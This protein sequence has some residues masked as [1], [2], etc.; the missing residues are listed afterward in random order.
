MAEPKAKTLQQKLGFFDE[1]L[2]KPLHDD[3][4]KW[5]D[6]NAEEIIYG[7]YPQLLQFSD[8]KM[9]ELRKRCT[10]IL[11]SN[12]EIVKSNINKFKERILW[13]ENRISES[14]DKVTKEQ[15]DFHQIT[16]DESEKEILVLMEKIS[17]SEKALIDLNKNSIFTND[18]PERNKIKVLSRIWELP[19]TSQSISK[20]SGY[21]STKNIIGFI[22]IMIKFSYSQLTVSGIDFYNKRIISELKW[23]QS[24]KK[25]D[26]IYGGPDEENEECIY[27]EVKT[28]I[29]SLGE[30][31]RQMR[32]YKEFIV[33][34]FLVICPDDSEQ[35]LI[36]EQ[37]FKF[38]KFKSL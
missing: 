6:Q 36:E 31:F 13:L 38:L 7:V 18:V 23:T 19:V 1:D 15:Y 9:E 32:M 11:E 5:V 35:S 8:L 16:I 30:L 25:V 3:I 28:K 20:T 10:S 24:Y 29:P 22:D 12:T 21:T 37:G 4:L 14:K 26:Y 33:G 17:T 2:K 34:D 27:I